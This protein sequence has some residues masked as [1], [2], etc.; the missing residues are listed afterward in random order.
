[1]GNVA[2]VG[3][4]LTATLLVAGSMVCF[5][6]E[7]G[8]GFEAG[9]AHGFGLGGEYPLFEE[10]E[11]TTHQR[12]RWIT[13]LLRYSGD[14]RPTLLRERTLREDLERELESAAPDVATLGEDVLALH[15]LAR[16]RATVRADLEAALMLILSR[17]QQ[18]RLQALRAASRACS[19]QDAGAW[20]PPVL[21][22]GVEPI[23]L[24]AFRLTRRNEVW[25]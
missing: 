22:G 25:P 16:V 21:D 18:S 19:G 1:M 13:T 11:L 7:P 17:E 8:A 2:I 4:G 9:G 14:N 12:Q 15:E 23:E 5:G 10:L 6:P 24:D 3:A 20:L